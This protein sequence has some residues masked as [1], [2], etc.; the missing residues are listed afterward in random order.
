MVGTQL[1]QQSRVLNP[2][3]AR[4]H[5]RHFSMQNLYC[6]PD[7]VNGNIDQ[8]FI[9]LNV[10]KN[11]GRSASRLLRNIAQR[12][13]VCLRRSLASLDD[14]CC[15]SKSPW[16]LSTICGAFVVRLD[17]PTASPYNPVLLDIPVVSLSDMRCVSTYPRH[18][19]VICG[20]TRRRCSISR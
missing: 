18:L 11:K 13:V 20:M 17:V 5:K 9:T 1:V 8:K 16:H 2:L 14:P 7:G 15:D 10:C 4:K 3:L 19:S 12:S 6:S